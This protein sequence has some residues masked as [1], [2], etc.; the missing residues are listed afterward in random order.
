MDKRNFKKTEQTDRK[1]EKRDIKKA[2]KP[3]KRVFDFDTNDGKVPQ[4]KLDPKKGEKQA[5]KVVFSITND[6]KIYPDRGDLKKA[7]RLPIKA[8]NAVAND[9][10]VH[11]DRG[12]SDRKI[13]KVEKPKLTVI[14]KKEET[15]TRPENLISKENVKKPDTDVNKIADDKR[16]I[17]EKYTLKK[18]PLQVIPNVM[19]KEELLKV[20]NNIKPTVAEVKSDRPP[21]KPSDVPKEKS[22]ESNESKQSVTTNNPPKPE[23]KD[24]VQRKP[25][26]RT[27]ASKNDTKVYKAVTFVDQKKN[28]PT[29][30]LKIPNE[31]VKNS[32]NVTEGSVN[33]KKITLSKESIKEKPLKRK[34]RRKKDKRSRRIASPVLSVKARSPPTEVAKWAP[35]SINRHTKPYYEAWVSTTLAAISKNSRRDKLFLEKQSILQS[36]Q[37]ALTERPET[38]ELV[39]ENFTDE[40]YTGRIKVKQR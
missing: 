2:E 6:S 40:K 31:T 36:F 20:G 16:K 33:L 4:D 26:I 37:R 38:P 29:L 27:I 9:V 11:P 7:E 1:Q 3:V 28:K 24:T 21:K 34:E 8:I 32:K 17:R 22:D 15:K 13:I 14:V 30:L 25:I 39:Y 12:D 19:K 5:K 18:S 35:S 23:K 10:K